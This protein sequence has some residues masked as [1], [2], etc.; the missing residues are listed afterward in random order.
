MRSF[1]CETNDMIVSALSSLYKTWQHGTN[2]GNGR[3]SSISMRSLLNPPPPPPS[4]ITTT[5]GMGESL[6]VH[7]D[8]TCTTVMLINMYFHHVHVEQGFSKSG[9]R[10]SSI[11][12]ARLCCFCSISIFVLLYISI[13]IALRSGPFGFHWNLI[14]PFE[15]KVWEPVM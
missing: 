2:K 10:S 15:G 14:R 1:S 13:D 11:W 6:Y 7:Y 8:Y 3:D 12:P 5:I 4:P 9:P